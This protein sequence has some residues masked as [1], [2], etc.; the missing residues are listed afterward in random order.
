MVLVKPSAAIT[1]SAVP[2]S[3]EIGASL[4]FHVV[5]VTAA[6]STDMSQDFIEGSISF[7]MRQ[8]DI[9]MGMKKDKP[10]SVVG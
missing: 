3:I 1:K 10:E 2:E 6:V 5:A 8:M 4:L 9:E 7:F